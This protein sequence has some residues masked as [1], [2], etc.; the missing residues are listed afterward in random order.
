MRAR[1]SSSCSARPSTGATILIGSFTQVGR[2]DSVFYFSQKFQVFD[3]IF[4]NGG[5]TSGIQSLL[6]QRAVNYGH[7]PQQG[8]VN[9]PPDEVLVNFIDNHDV[10]RF[11]FNRMDA[12]GPA[13]LRAALTY[14]LTE[15]GIPCVY[16]GTEQEYA[17]G[18]DPSNRKPLWH[19]NYDTQGETFQH[20]AQL[21]RIR[22]HY[23]ALRRGSFDIKWLTDRTG[24]ADD[25]GIIAFERRTN[26]GDY[27]LVV[28]NAQ[29]A[30]PSTTAHGGDAMQVSADA[31]AVLVDALTGDPQT[32]GA[33]QTMSLQIPPY[34]ALIL[35]PQADYTAL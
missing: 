26:A 8:G 1:T 32:V 4:S 20:I 35:V 11:L 33:D 14:L 23:T 34:G 3:A 31:G 28:I 18:N 2:L 17:G 13:A 6:D 25:A 7:D 10:P 24:D 21:T 19:S 22:R 16:Y 9:V 15:Q 29:G 27:A 12:Q 30:H 5:P